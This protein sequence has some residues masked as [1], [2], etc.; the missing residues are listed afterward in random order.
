M[1]LVGPVGPAGVLAAPRLGQRPAAASSRPRPCAW[2]DLGR[3]RRLSRAWC[4][5]SSARAAPGFHVHLV[6]SMAKRCRFLAEVVDERST[7]RPRSTTPGRKTCDLA[8]DIV[9]A[10]ACAPL[11]RLLGYAQPYLQAGRDGPV[12]Q[13]T[14]CC[15]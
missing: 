4:W 12:P 13:G 3:R 8:V 14:R 2:A 7:C 6:E 10:R 15:G 9:T 1:N 11:L 5:R